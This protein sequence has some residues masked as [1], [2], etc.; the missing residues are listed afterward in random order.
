MDREPSEELIPS[1]RSP[2]EVLP[3]GMSRLRTVLTTPLGV[4]TTRRDMMGVPYPMVD[5]SHMVNVKVFGQR[6]SSN[7]LKAIDVN[8]LGD[9]LVNML[10]VCNQEFKTKQEIIDWKPMRL[11][12]T[13][14]RAHLSM[15]AK[16]LIG[17]L[18]WED[19]EERITT[20]ELLHPSWQRR[21]ETKWLLLPSQEP[22]FR[23][24]PTPAPSS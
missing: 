2:P 13:A 9:T 12:R 7:D 18:L 16:H 4:R 17:A 15:E 8:Y 21:E 1:V 22:G 3:P 10:R 14:T 11:G 5:A 20:K 19:E 6:L 24:K 23:E